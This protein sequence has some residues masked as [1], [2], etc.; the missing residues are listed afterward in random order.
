MSSQYPGVYPAYKKDKTP[1]FRASLTFRGKHISLGSYASPQE[2]YQAYQEGLFLLTG[3][4][5][6]LS[7]YS[8]RLK[9]C[10]PFRTDCR[11]ESC[12]FNITPGHNTAICAKQCCSY[13]I[14]GIGGIGISSGKKCCLNQ[15]LT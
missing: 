4:G 15:L 10:H 3:T 2:A 11:P 14:M 12:I 5:S 8:H 6:T 9:Y 13:F 7:D 1:Y